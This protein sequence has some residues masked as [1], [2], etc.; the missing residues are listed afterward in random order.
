MDKNK[1]KAANLAFIRTF[2]QSLAGLIAGLSITGAV[3][4][5]FISNFNSIELWSV[6][7]ASILTPL[8]AG[9]TAWLQVVAGGIPQSYRDVE[10]GYVAKHKFE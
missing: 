10:G 3:V 9:A 5:N 4:S 7:I 6:V 8:L 1:L 2:A